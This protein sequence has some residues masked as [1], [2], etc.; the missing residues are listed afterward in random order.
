MKAFF[1][2]D[3]QLDFI[4][5]GGALY[6]AGGERLIPAI[7]KLNQYAGEKKIP[8]ISSVDAHP[9][10]AA[11]FKVWPPH[12]V[13][14]TFGQQKPAS[15]LLAERVVVPWDRD[16]DIALAGADIAQGAAQYIVE[17]NDLD[18]FTNPHF[19]ALLSALGVT[20]CIVYG[21]FIDYCVKCAIMGLARTGR[22]VSLVTDASA[23][24]AKDAGDAAIRDF[25]AAG[26][27]LIALSQTIL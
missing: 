13:A 5:P 27:Q 26:G 7:A 4:A 15:T 8:V 19:P 11:E 14:G 2:I 25:V 12:C 3:T 24:I 9:E 22:R 10:N 18:V 23:A 6:G 21:V 16:F 17:K 20:E 1:D